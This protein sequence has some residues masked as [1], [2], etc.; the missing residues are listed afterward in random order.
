MLCLRSLLSLGLFLASQCLL[1]ED[2]RKPIAALDCATLLAEYAADEELGHFDPND[3]VASERTVFVIGSEGEDSTQR[4]L[5]EKQGAKW[6]SPATS[7]ETRNDPQ[8]DPR[9]TLD[10]LGRA[11]ARK[12]GFELVGENRIYVPST[13]MLNE[14]LRGISG[15][16]FYDQSAVN[17]EVYLREFAEGPNAALPMDTHGANHFLHDISF[18]MGILVLPDSAL[19]IMRERASFSLFFSDFLKRQPVKNE[20]EKKAY[21]AWAFLVRTME[22]SRIDVGTGLLSPTFAKSTSDFAA[23]QDFEAFKTS[24]RTSYDLLDLD[25]VLAKELIADEAISSFS[26]SPRIS[27]EMPEAKK[28]VSPDRISRLL[29]NSYLAWKRLK[30]KTQF[31]PFRK[32]RELLPH[33]D[34]CQQL[35]AKRK[36]VV[37]ALLALSP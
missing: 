14:R 6:S 32:S 8:G 12:L 30:P 16:T 10:V 22:A 33:E 15:I 9:W 29:V 36:S 13:K 19:K 25:G 20:E 18:H 27:R 4:F 11:G 17:T 3:A 35:L 5:L 26:N 37:Q 21:R 2:N 34:F 28:I 31:S 24:M 23:N 7:L 1:A